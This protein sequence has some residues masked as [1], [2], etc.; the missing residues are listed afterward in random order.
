VVFS[1]KNADRVFGQIV[2]DINEEY[3]EAVASKRFVLARWIKVR[4][5]ISLMHAVVLQIGVSTIKRFV[6]LWKIIP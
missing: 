5:F 2:N 1:K 4:G 3:N 6:E